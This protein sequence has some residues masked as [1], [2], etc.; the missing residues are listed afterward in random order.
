MLNQQ[1]IKISKEKDGQADYDPGTL[2]AISITATVIFSVDIMLGI[3]IL[4]PSIRRNLSLIIFMFQCLGSQGRNWL[5]SFPSS[6]S[7]P[8]S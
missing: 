3:L 1:L 6:L 4:L 8:D 7:I 5:V 2:M